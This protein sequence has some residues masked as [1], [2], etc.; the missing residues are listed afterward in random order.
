LRMKKHAARGKHAEFPTSDNF[1][2][3]GKGKG[4][5][6]GAGMFDGP[7]TRERNE[8]TDTTLLFGKIIPRKR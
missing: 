4:R 1:L 8:R 7:P 5:G 3:L 6:R 2:D